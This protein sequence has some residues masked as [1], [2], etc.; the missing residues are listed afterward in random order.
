MT[1]DLLFCDIVGNTNKLFMV[2]WADNV[3]EHIVLR[4]ITKIS[5]ENFEGSIIVRLYNPH[6]MITIRFKS[7]QLV[8]YKKLVETLGEL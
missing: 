7:N 8:W 3:T 1:I 5:K 2:Q 6:E 4:H